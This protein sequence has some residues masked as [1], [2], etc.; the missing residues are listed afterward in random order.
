MEDPRVPTKDVHISIH[1]NVAGRQPRR[2]VACKRTK[3][4]VMFLIEILYL[5]MKLLTLG[6]A[7]YQTAPNLLYSVACCQTGFS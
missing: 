2:Y 5:I 7:L 1:R 6:E 3:R 4:S